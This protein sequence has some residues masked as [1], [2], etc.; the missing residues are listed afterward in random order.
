MKTK[1][2]RKLKVNDAQHE[3]NQLTVRPSSRNQPQNLEFP[4]NVHESH[5][6]IAASDAEKSFKEK[7]VYTSKQITP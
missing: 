7:G 6:D 1:E 5:M 2:S 4:V 3:P